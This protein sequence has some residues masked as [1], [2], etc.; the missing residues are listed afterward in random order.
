MLLFTEMTQPA[1]MQRILMA[2]DSR[3]LRQLYLV[4]AATD[5]SFRLV[6]MLIGLTG[7]VLYPTI[8]A[9]SLISHIVGESLPV[10][11]KGLAIAGI[12]SMVMSTADSNLHAAGLTLTHDV[13]KPLCKKIQLDIDELRWA[14]YSTLLIGLSAILMGLQ[15]TNLLSLSLLALKFTGPILSFPL[16]TGILGLKPTKR[17]F[18][19]ASAIT[20]I[21]FVVSNTLLAEEHRHLDVLIST[22]TNG[23]ALLGAHMVEHSGLVIV[24]RDFEGTIEEDLGQPKSK[25]LPTYH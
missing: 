4:T 3:Q 10:I 21:V 14:R 23:I 12:L 13:V 15:A 18:Y 19:I 24:K 22:V 11:L 2:K 7:L 9:N 6:T 5:C 16:L 20:S 17:A 1:A 25:E 8:E